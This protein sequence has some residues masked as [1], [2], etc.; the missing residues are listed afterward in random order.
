MLTSE[1]CLFCFL[2][3]A[4]VL[5]ALLQE[6]MGFLVV[7]VAQAGQNVPVCHGLMGCSHCCPLFKKI[8]SSNQRIVCPMR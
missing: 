6:C 3:N 1:R 4:I 8:A 7:V 2:G 5:I